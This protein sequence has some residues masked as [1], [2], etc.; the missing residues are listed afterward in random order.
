MVPVFLCVFLRVKP[1]LDSFRRRVISKDLVAVT[2]NI[3][4]VL[5]KKEDDYQSRVIYSLCKSSGSS[6]RL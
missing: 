2:K 6:R 1:L 3:E 5:Y 4:S